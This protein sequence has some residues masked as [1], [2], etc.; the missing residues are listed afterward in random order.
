MFSFTGRLRRSHLAN[1]SF[2]DIAH[3]GDHNGDVNNVIDLIERKMKV[4]SE[5]VDERRRKDVVLPHRWLIIPLHRRPH[6]SEQIDVG[7]RE[8]VIHLQIFPELDLFGS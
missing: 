1:H 6:V 3:Q 5:F 4:S 2:E 8:S 7:R